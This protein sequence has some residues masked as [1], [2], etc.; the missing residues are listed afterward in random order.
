M[1]YFVTELITTT[2]STYRILHEQ[3][4][5]MKKK[6]QTETHEVVCI[7][8]EIVIV[9]KVCKQSWTIFNWLCWL[10]YAWILHNEW[11][12]LA[13]AVVR[14]LWSANFAASVRSIDDVTRKCKVTARGTLCVVSRWKF[15]IVLLSRFRA[16]Q[17]AR[18]WFRYRDIGVRFH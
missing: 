6:I 4:K 11:A 12:R 16:I 15:L 18:N 7:N 5:E 10:R 3:Q 1:C 8:N 14:N 13:F 2:V 17:T 9:G